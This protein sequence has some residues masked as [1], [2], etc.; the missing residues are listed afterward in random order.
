MAWFYNLILS[1]FSEIGLVASSRRLI[2]P[3]A[4]M[5]YKSAFSLKNSHISQICAL[6]KTSK[7][8]FFN[9]SQNRPI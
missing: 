2:S 8:P 7:L 6:S 3:S 4:S 9:G 1:H 5:V